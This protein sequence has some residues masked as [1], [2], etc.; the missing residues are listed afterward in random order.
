MDSTRRELADCGFLAQDGFI[1]S[2]G[3]TSQLPQTADTILD[4]KG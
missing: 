4:L 1:Q 3:S 2:I